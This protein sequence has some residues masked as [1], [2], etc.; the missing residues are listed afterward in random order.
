MDGNEIQ[1]LRLKQRQAECL[2]D[3]VLLEITSPKSE[4]GENI[5]PRERDELEACIQT[6]RKI[7]EAIAEKMLI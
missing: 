2:T 1:K 3:S 4:G 7:S 5:T 6:E